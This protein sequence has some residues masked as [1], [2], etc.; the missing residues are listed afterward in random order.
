MRATKLWRKVKKFFPDHSWP[1]PHHGAGQ[2]RAPPCL[3]VKDQESRALRRRVSPHRSAVI[4]RRGPPGP[5]R[6]PN[7][8]RAGDIAPLVSPLRLQTN[9]VSPHLQKHAPLQERISREAALSSSPRSSATE[10][11]GRRRRGGG[12]AVM[13]PLIK[14]R[15]FARFQVPH[16]SVAS[17]LYHRGSWRRSG[18]VC[19]F[20]F[21]SINSVFPSLALFGLVSWP[22]KP[23]P[24]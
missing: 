20:C 11:E 15:L 14:V 19:V 17:S 12:A 21:C 5:I 24:H 1:R 2:Q 8:P 22:P 23:S 7:L 4:A 9:A 13:A 16:F 6:G 3:K 18:C 10:T